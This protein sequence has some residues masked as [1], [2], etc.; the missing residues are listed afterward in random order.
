MLGHFGACSHRDDLQPQSTYTQLLTGSGNKAWHLV[1][2]EVFDQEIS[3]GV[4]PIASLLE[5]CEADDQFVFYADAQR[6]L[7]FANGPLKC[8]E[9]EPDGI[10]ADTW[11]LRNGDSVLELLLPFL[12]RKV[13]WTIRELTGTSLT[14]E[15]FFEDQNVRYRFTFAAAE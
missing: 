12:A 15:Y 10:F 13:P 8:D 1:S 14:L 5:P 7:E 4:Q 11:T 2:Y 3:A 6:K 9:H